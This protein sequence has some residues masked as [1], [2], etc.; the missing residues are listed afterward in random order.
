MARA[1]GGYNTRI[2]ISDNMQDYKDPPFAATK[3]KKKD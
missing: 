3:Q 1:P 2:A